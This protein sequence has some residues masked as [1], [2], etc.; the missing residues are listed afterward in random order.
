[1]NALQP[2]D[3]R[4]EW[5][6]LAKSKAAY[7]DQTETVKVHLGNM[8]LMC[9]TAGRLERQLQYIEELSNLYSADASAE[10]AAVFSL[11][12]EA[13]RLS[14]R[15]TDGISALE[16]ALPVLIRQNHPL[17]TYT[18]HN[19][20]ITYRNLGNIQKS[21]YYH[22]LEKE[23]SARDNDWVSLSRSNLSLGILFQEELEIGKAIVHYEAAQKAMEKEETNPSAKNS[24]IFRLGRES[25][26]AE[27]TFGFSTEN[28][29]KFNKIPVLGNKGSLET[30]IGSYHSALQSLDEAI[31]MCQDLAQKRYEAIWLHKK[32]MAHSSLGEY[33]LALDCQNQ[34]MEI[35]TSIGAVRAVGFAHFGIG[36][37]L[38]VQYGLQKLIE[39]PKASIDHF[40]EA[41]EIGQKTE[42]PRD[43]QEF[44]ADLAEAYLLA[45][46][47]S[48]A[49]KMIA[50]LL[51][52]QSRE[53]K[54]R[55]LAVHGILLACAGDLSSG[56]LA[57]K[58]AMTETEKLLENGPVIL[59]V[60]YFQARIMFYLAIPNAE[61]PKTI[62]D[63]L[64]KYK[65]VVE[66]APL[67]RGLMIN[68][69][70]VLTH[71][72]AYLPQNENLFSMIRS[73][74]ERNAFSL[75]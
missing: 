7:L 39:F 69:L 65:R 12:G 28:W 31:Q 35:A 68:E 47:L 38:I 27:I 33:D 24:Y 71:L 10:A 8:A 75:L 74:L 14:G 4:L 32:G 61:K 5:L 36:R 37:A 73:L 41:F 49:N 19:L 54:Y 60:L 16:R 17:L 25:L 29:Q 72:H 22:Q 46:N 66:L 1:L 55:V 9:R 2:P 3:E 6:G 56:R 58:A 50:L 67:A 13:Y 70:L 21:I 11:L 20:G 42:N 40:L 48:E 62:P 51:N 45:S 44:G 43:M 23:V 15:L 59:P 34:S 64:E 63:A 53:N 26:R 30:Q 57:L 52:L 18:Y